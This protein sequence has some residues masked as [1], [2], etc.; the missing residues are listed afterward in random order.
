MKKLM[1]IAFAVAV[2]IALVGAYRHV[3]AE[4]SK[5]PNNIPVK[6]T[7]SVFP[8]VVLPAHTLLAAYIDQGDFD[9]EVGSG[10]TAID[11]PVTIN[12]QSASGCTIGSEHWIQVGGNSASGNLWALCTAVD[13]NIQTCPYQGYVASDGSYEMGSFTQS[14]S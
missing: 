12:C 4:A 5:S 8:A 6:M 14:V 9:A 3:Q 11:G 2:V 13:G 10:F 7:G 1:T